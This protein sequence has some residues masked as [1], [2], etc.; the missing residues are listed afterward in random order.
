MTLTEILKIAKE[1]S[2]IVFSRK[3]FDHIDGYDERSCF[4][5]NI[6]GRINEAFK[7]Y[8]PY[9]SVSFHVDSLIA[10]D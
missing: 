3:I 2:N 7:D 10:E 8:N 4:R 6:K 1:N 5:V 9:T